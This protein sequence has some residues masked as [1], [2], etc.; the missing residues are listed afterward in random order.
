MCDNCTEEGLPVGDQGPAGDPAFLALPATGTGVPH[1]DA[2]NAWVEIK[3]SRFQ[4]TTDYSVPFT[5]HKINIWVSAGTGVYRIRDLISGNTILADKNVTST[6]TTN[7]ETTLGLE[8]YNSTN[9]LI[10]VEMKSD[11]A[12]KSITCGTQ[13]FAYLK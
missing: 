5:S 8:V 9:A 13:T 2:T 10:V 4:F 6:S 3:G 1:V 11:T 12:G 7:I